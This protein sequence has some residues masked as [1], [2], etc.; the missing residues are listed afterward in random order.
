MRSKVVNP[1]S[2]PWSIAIA[3]SMGPK[4][5]KLV[6]EQFEKKNIFKQHEKVKVYETKSFSYTVGI[7]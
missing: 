4:S 7:S 3:N 2:W 6:G 5:A 1:V